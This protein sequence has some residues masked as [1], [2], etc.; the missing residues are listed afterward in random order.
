MRTKVVLVVLIFGASLIP[1][2]QAGSPEKLEDVGWVFGGLYLDANES[3]NVTSSLSELPAIA[4][5]YTATWCT[6]CVTVENSLKEIEENNNMKTYHFHRFINENE[7]P[8]GSQEGDDRWISRYGDRIPPTVIFNG[9]IRQIGKMPSEEGRSLQDDYNQSLSISINL[10][11]GASTFGWAVTNDTNIATWNLAVNMS[12]FPDDSEI[13]SYLWVV[14]KVAYFPDGG[15]EQEYYYESV[16]SIVD[17][18]NSTSGSMEVV[19]PLAY[20]GNDLQVHLIHEVVL[21][22]PDIEIPVE[23]VKEETEDDKK[24]D[25][26]SLPSISM[27]AVI[28]LN[29]LAAVIAQRRH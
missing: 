3:G 6:S 15:N 1:I 19:L 4:E 8:L 20:D 12:N 16:R 21:P 11:E 26:S 29:V 7:D 22:E 17:L 5:D 28:I 2:S 10:G 13:K 18:G 27:F 23:P 14:E 9:T 24:D 25:D